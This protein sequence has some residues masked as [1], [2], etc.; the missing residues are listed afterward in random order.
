MSLAARAAKDAPVDRTT[1]IEKAEAKGE[2][3]RPDRQSRKGIVVYV[4]RGTHRR[5]RQIGL[6]GGQ[7]LQELMSEAV[8][9]FLAAPDGSGPG[10]GS[11]EGLRATGTAGAGAAGSS[12]AA[13]GAAAETAGTSARCG[14]LEPEG[15]EEGR[16][17]SEAP[18]EIS[19][20]SPAGGLRRQG[21]SAH[22]GLGNLGNA[23]GLGRRAVEQQP[24]VAVARHRRGPGIGQG[25]LQSGVSRTNSGR[26]AV[27]ALRLVDTI[28]H[29]R[30]HAHAGLGGRRRRRRRRAAG[31]RRMVRG[32]RY[33]AGSVCH[34]G[35]PG[36][37]GERGRGAGGRRP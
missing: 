17:S 15:F 12:T 14:S 8:E 5:L 4:D 32:G 18:P 27:V 6:D 20:S 19:S 29:L 24:V 9:R 25:A 31:T 26:H 37:N 3:G 33:G 10:A 34:G 22:I 2:R 7:T 23:V 11:D 30:R 28:A 21:R 35:L 1:R 13:G 36:N 16:A